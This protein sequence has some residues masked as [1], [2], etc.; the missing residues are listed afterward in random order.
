MKTAPVVAA[1]LEFDSEGVPVSRRYAD[2]Y[3]PRSGALQQAAHVFLHGNDL[4][5]RWRGREQFAILETGFGLG[6]NFLATL[7]AWR[8]DPARPARLHFVSI[9]QH[10]FAR[11]DL[12]RAHAASPLRDLTDALVQAWPPLTPDLHRLDFAAGKVQLLLGFGDVAAWLPA[13]VAR[14]DAFYLDGFAPDRNPDMWQPRIFKA[15]AR[16]AN[17]GATA[18][19]WS[20]A[21]SVRDGLAE[22]GF[23]V[24]RAPGSGGKREITLARFAPRFEPRRAPSR[25][26]AAPASGN[27][28]H[29]VVVGAGLA[30]CAV[31][32]ALAEQGWTSTLL[33]RLPT[34]AGATSGNRA[35][36]FHGIVNAQDGAHAR[37]NRA[38]ALQ[39]TSAV[40]RAIELDASAG[41]CNG[42]LRMEARADLAE[43]Q[44]SIARLGLPP[45]YVQALDADQASRRAGLP[46]AAPAW[47]YP[48]AG[49]V[50]PAALAASLLAQAGARATVRTG[51]EVASLRRA[52]ALWQALDPAGGVIAEAAVVVLANALDAQR[53]LGAPNWPLV[54]VR[55]QTSELPVTTPGLVLPRLPLTGNGYVL[56]ALPGGIALFGAT[57][58]LGDLESR[59]RAEDQHHN[60]AQL[61]RLTGSLPTGQMALAG[62]V[63]W[64]CVTPDRLPVIGAAP[65]MKAIAAEPTLR[66]DQ[67]RFVPRRSGLYVHTALASRG[68]TWALLGART[69][70][71]IVAAAP[72]PL[73]ASLLDAVDAGRFAAREAR[74][75]SQSL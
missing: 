11:A 60:L 1:Q 55:G 21:R 67:A 6:N 19:T 58:Q 48:G 4:P 43:M 20:V 17:P 50:A 75:R 72:C 32:L 42:V 47:F 45:E 52:G 34:I 35:G 8:A 28:R 9:E 16:L 68:I 22:A 31:A 40:R 70:A 69:L 46:L 18:A 5:A 30:G 26:A 66:L 62:R 44:A 14:I 33:E 73:D 38:A 2:R 59:L 10:P 12:A 13:L 23:E 54:A 27:T 24:E 15:L 29:A 37:F 41:E 61:A 71:S 3:H 25:L 36:V 74:R 63:G 7:D 49:W 51:I 57:S 65:D 53:L 56:P 64:R 39:A